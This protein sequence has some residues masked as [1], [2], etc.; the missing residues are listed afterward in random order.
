E[1]AKIPAEIIN[2]VAEGSP[3]GVDAIRAKTIHMVI[4]TTSGAK[5]I[6]DSYSIRR[7]TLLANIPYFTTISAGMAAVEAI[8]ARSEAG[9]GSTSRRGASAVGGRAAAPP[10][11]EELAGMARGARGARGARRS[12]PFDAPR[13]LVGSWKGAHVFAT[14]Y[15]R[16]AE[17]SPRSTAPAARRP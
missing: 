8:E 14:L 3:H 6:R 15:A 1:R 4:N 17:I 7:Q 10:H 11:G 16:D 2:K 9:A 12:P 5:E 13:E